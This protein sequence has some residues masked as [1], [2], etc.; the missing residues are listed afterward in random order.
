MFCWWQKTVIKANE[1]TF[2]V[3]IICIFF[4][5]LQNMSR[6]Q[7]LVRNRHSNRYATPWFLEYHREASGL[8]FW[9][10]HLGFLQPSV[11]IPANTCLIA[12]PYNN[13]W[14]L[15]TSNLG[16]PF[17]GRHVLLG[18]R[19]RYAPYLFILWMLFV[20]VKYFPSCVQAP[21]VV[22][23]EIAR[24]SISFPKLTLGK[25]DRKKCGVCVQVDQTT[26]D[27]DVFYSSCC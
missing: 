11:T 13:R 26:A 20:H 5:G 4:Y 6:E 16:S 19:L 23:L 27:A 3:I 15:F 17:N 8:A 1:I 18:E 22:R 25:K 14:P 7:R 24:G 10:C 21:F 12:P 9:W 2:M